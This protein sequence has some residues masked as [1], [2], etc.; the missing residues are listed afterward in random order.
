MAYN[1]ILTTRVGDIVKLEEKMENNPL[2][3]QIIRMSNIIARKNPKNNKT[4]EQL[5]HTEKRLFYMSL[6]Q[7]KN[8]DDKGIVKLKKTDV[9]EKLGINDKDMYSRYRELFKEMQFKTYY[10]FDTE[11]GWDDGFLIYR[12]AMTKHY[13]HVYFDLTYIPLL[14][15]L[16]QSTTMFFDDILKFECTHSISLYQFIRSLNKHP[17]FNDCYDFST[18]ELKKLFGLSED[19]YMRKKDGF[20]RNQFEKQTIDKAVEEIN[21]K[22]SLIQNVR[23]EKHKKGNRVAFY[24]VY[25]ENLQLPS[26]DDENISLTNT[27]TVLAE[28]P[29]EDG[30]CLNY[31]LFRECLS[32]LEPITNAQIREI[33]EL[34]TECVEQSNTFEIDMYKYLSSKITQLKA[35]NQPVTSK[36][37]L[38]KTFIRADINKK[39]EE[40]YG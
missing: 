21:S 40:I 11:D 26:L 38:I 13:F 22:S 37:G 6:A 39:F 17:K 36:R 18:S 15:E 35:Y 32:Y 16:Q 29:I 10:E 5:T 30:D 4:K 3:N 19:S 1:V 25:F 2:D 24:R 12:T 9:F 31:Q 7:A 34:A 33:Y 28:E 23:Y 20:N 14:R 27:D 8:I